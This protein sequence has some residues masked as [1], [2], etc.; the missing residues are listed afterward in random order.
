M[1]RIIYAS[2]SYER[3]VEDRKE[4]YSEIRNLIWDFLNGEVCLISA[5]EILFMAAGIFCDKCVFCI[6]DC[7]F[8]P[9]ESKWL[10]Q[11]EAFTYQ[12]L[13]SQE[14]HSMLS[15]LSPRA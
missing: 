9:I 6:L 5:V 14:V 15:F 10:I 13:K 3:Q 12:G 4:K 8:L 1:L 7:L 2:V 11:L